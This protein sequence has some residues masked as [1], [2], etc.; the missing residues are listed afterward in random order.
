MAYLTEQEVRA[1]AERVTRRLQK[2]AGRILSEAT[3]ALADERFDVFLSHSSA[4]PED[5]LLGV[6]ALLEDRGLSVYVDKYSDPH[7]SPERVTRETA[8]I[9]RY[10]MRCSNTLLYVHSQYS[11]KSRWMPWELGF[12]DGLKGSVGIIPITR[13][14]E[15][16]FK[17]EEYLNLYPH[18]DIETSR[19]T[20]KRELWITEAADT[21][22]SLARWAKGTA[23]IRKR[24]N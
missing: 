12:F 18:V 24:V 17:G 2:S 23:K 21:Y 8:E 9:L 15:E 1:R 20:K 3:A 22:A 10:R 13:N 19:E 5:I 6:V 4:E 11:K 14:Q 7:L 16:A